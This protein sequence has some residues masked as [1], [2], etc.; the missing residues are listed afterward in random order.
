MR[1]ISLP[2][3][4][5][6]GLGLAALLS[7]CNSLQP[8]STNAEYQKAQDRPRLQMPAG[9][10]GSEKLGGGTIIPPPAKETA[11]L[12]PPPKC[13][14]EPPP[15]FGP[16]KDVASDSVEAAVGAWAAGWAARNPDAVA[17]MYSARFQ[18]PEGGAGPYL[19]QRRQEVATGQPPAPKLEE[20]SVTAAGPDRRVVTFVQRFGDK[21]IR[22]EL[23]LQRE[24]QGWRI[25]AE[26]TLEAR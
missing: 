24:P 18:A 10:P 20:V 21:P 12:D 6:F 13:L 23:T 19:D 25:V 14:D 26:R 15:F 11:K 2:A 9:V 8:C 22:K 4:L 17:S 7:G 1:L 5:V 3:S 16:R